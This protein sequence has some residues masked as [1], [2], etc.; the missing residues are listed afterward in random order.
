MSYEEDGTISINVAL[1][2]H[3]NGFFEFRVCDVKYCGGEIS[4]NVYEARTV[5]FYKE[6][7]TRLVR[8]VENGDALQ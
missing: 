8:Q 2:Q 5:M 1:T 3:H 4:E 6:P 7:L